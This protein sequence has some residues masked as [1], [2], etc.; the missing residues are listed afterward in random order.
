MPYSAAFR[1][2]IVQKLMQPG[3]PTQGA[4]SRETG[5]PQTTLSRWVQRA[6]T[7]VPMASKRSTKRQRRTADEKLRVVMEALRL[8]DEELGAFLRREGV[9]EAELQQWREAARAGLAATTGDRKSPELQ[10]I[11]QLEGELLRKEKALAE[12][13]AIL[14]LRKKAQALWGDVDADTDGNSAK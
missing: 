7:M 11:K 8:P 3:G 12:V 5:V 1:S 2:K 14:V 6:R 10:R 9:T 13:S 4:I